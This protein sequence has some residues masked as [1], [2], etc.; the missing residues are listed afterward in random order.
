MEDQSLHGL[1]VA[2][3]NHARRTRWWLG[4]HLNDLGACKQKREVRSREE[5]EE[6]KK[7]AVLRHAP[8]MA[9]VDLRGANVGTVGVMPRRSGGGGTIEGDDEDDGGDDGEAACAPGDD[10]EVGN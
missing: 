1:A 9:V 2:L 6:K 10:G 8:Y 5:E 4:N 7:R 3:N